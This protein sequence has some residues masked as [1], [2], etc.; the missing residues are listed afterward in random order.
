MKHPAAQPV[1][2]RLVQKADPVRDFMF[3]PQGSLHGGVIAFVADVSMG[4]LLK[5]SYGVAGAPREIRLQ[6]LLPLHP[7]AARCVSRF[8]RKGRSV[9]FLEAVLSGPDGVPA[10][11]ASSTWQIPRPRPA[12]AASGAVGS[13][14]SPRRGEGGPREAGG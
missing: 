12:E 11:V 4:H 6:Y 2:R 14:P 7:P 5:H 3:N 8:L 1:L 13:S 9:C 10:V